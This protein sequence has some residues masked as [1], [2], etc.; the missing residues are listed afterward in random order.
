[1]KKINLE[2][3]QCKRVQIFLLYSQ[4]YQ[5]QPLLL[6]K[7]PNLLMMTILGTMC[8]DAADKQGIKDTVVECWAKMVSALGDNS[9]DTRC[10]SDDPPV[11]A[12]DREVV[13]ATPAR[14]S[15]YQPR[16]VRNEVRDDNPDLESRMMISF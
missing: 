10:P 8:A 9:S 3:S 7:L 6:R 11:D 2:S 15:R 12:V 4:D 13:P 1:M 16:R 5:L 14:S